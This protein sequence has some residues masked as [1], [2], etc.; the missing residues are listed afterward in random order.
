MLNRLTPTQQKNIALIE[1]LIEI[2]YTKEEIKD[3]ILRN[4]YEKN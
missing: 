2:G 3:I 1:S 4:T